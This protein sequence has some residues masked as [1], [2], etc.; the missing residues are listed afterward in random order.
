MYQDFPAFNN[1]YNE[2]SSAAKNDYSSQ[3]NY[4]FKPAYVKGFKRVQSSEDFFDLTVSLMADPSALAKKNYS[5]GD[6]SYEY[7][8]SQM[9][10]DNSRK[11]LNAQ[12]NGKRKGNETDFKVKYKTEPCKYWENKQSCP[13]GDQ[14][15]FAHGTVE[16]RD[17]IHI[18]TNYKTKKCVQY[19][20]HLYC[21]YGKRCQFLH[22]LRSLPTTQPSGPISFQKHIENPELLIINETDCMCLSRQLR[23]RLPIFQDIT[24]P[25]SEEEK[26]CSSSHACSH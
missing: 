23:P 5:H 3:E 10:F 2:M 19:H 11:A 6:L 18:S 21:P 4:D 14:C 26:S 22:N 8:M 16:M 9:Q 7:Y 12:L 1:F 20:D 13:F 15:A 24:R 17:K 25:E